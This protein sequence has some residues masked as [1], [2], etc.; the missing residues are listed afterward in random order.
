MKFK[1]E[2]VKPLGI[3]NVENETVFAIDPCYELCQGTE[4]HVK[5]GNW[6]ALVESGR[7]DWGVRT[8]G[9]SIF[10]SSQFDSIADDNFY[11]NPKK[12][13]KIVEQLSRV[14]ITGVDSGQSGFFLSSKP[15]DNNEDFDN[16]EGWY[17]SVCRV[18]SGGAVVPHGAVSCSGF[19]DG[20]YDVSVLKNKL[21][22]VVVARIEFINES[23]W[24]DEDDWENEEE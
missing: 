18:S 5:N 24:E 17:G 16:L 9:I 13:W 4:L 12:Y 19:G 11:F 22:Q 8:W 10:H 14:G 3:I 15:C 7:T 23:E 21:A 6:F 2:D 20:C 1:V